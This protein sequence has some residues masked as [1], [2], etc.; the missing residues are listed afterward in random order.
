[1]GPG[2]AFVLLHFGEYKKTKEKLPLSGKI[3]KADFTPARPGPFARAFDSM[4]SPGRHFSRQRRRVLQLSI[5][6]D[7]W[8]NIARSEVIIGWLLVIKPGV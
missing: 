6:F 4:W 3:P 1:M 7:L 2:Q 8:H 5:T